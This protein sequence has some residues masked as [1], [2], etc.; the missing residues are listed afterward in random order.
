MLSNFSVRNL[1]TA[2]TLRVWSVFATS[3]FQEG[4]M[5]SEEGVPKE[6]LTATFAMSWFWFPEAQFGCAPG[7]IR[8]KVGYTGGQKVSPT[9]RSLGDHTETLQLKYDP[10][11]TNYSN[12]LSIFWNNHDPTSRNK[13]QYMSAIF[14][15]DEEQRSLAE[16]SMK[17][18]QKS[19]SR[20]ITTKILPAQTFYDAED[21]H[22][23]YLLRRHF[24]I[25]QSLQLSD[26]QVITSHVA[27]RLNGYVN[28][29]GQMS[30]LLNEIGDWKLNE[31]QENMIRDAVANVRCV[32]GACSK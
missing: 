9:Y 28:G 7:V 8:T 14:Y 10:K 5:P 4:K 22:Q 29:H 32:G 26:P 25:F 20:P 19:V 1:F 23:K 27:A 16:E 17:T 3:S 2:A 31:K 24:K 30:G 6:L 21:Y 18:H 15:H 13:A 12:L 11:Q